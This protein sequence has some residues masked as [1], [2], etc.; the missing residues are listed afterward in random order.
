MSYLFNLSLEVSIQL[1]LFLFLFARFF[2]Y[3][4]SS[5]YVDIVVTACC[6]QFLFVFLCVFLKYQIFYNHEMLYVFFLHFCMVHKVSLCDLLMYGLVSLIINCL[7]LCSTCLSYS[8]DHFKN[9]PEY[10]TKDIA[11][12]FIPLM[13]FLQLSWLLLLLLLLIIIIIII[14]IICCSSSYIVH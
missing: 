5:S 10:L 8:L 6:N 13:R 1:F 9:G 4:F 3:C 14:I 2:F 11:Q 12:A 7:L